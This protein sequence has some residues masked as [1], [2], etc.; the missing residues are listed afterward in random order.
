MC[1]PSSLAFLFFYAE[2]YDTCRCSDSQP[3]SAFAMESICPP[4]IVLILETQGY[5]LLVPSPV[6]RTGHSS[7]S[8][9]PHTTFFSQSLPHLPLSILR[10]IPCTHFVPNIILLPRL[11]PLRVD[12]PQQS[13][14]QGHRRRLQF[15]GGAGTREWCA[16]LVDGCSHRVLVALRSPE[17]AARCR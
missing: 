8:V 2:K 9:V 14:V 3:N 11:C 1:T 16:A 17:N 13:W 7:C 6:S 10:T 15:G 12:G 4:Q 5:P